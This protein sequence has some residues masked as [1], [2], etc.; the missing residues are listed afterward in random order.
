M[1]EG[2]VRDRQAPGGVLIERIRH[3]RLKQRRNRRFKWPPF[4]LN[5]PPP[6]GAT[7][8]RESHLRCGLESRDTR[9]MRLIY[10]PKPSDCWRHS[11][12]TLPHS[13]RWPLKSASWNIPNLLECLEPSENGLELASCGCARH[14]FSFST[15]ERELP[16]AAQGPVS[17]AEAQQRLYHRELSRL[18]ELLHVPLKSFKQQRFYH[19]LQMIR[20]SL[21]K[22]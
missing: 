10:L 15:K 2:I 16:G 4:I 1:E 18:L 5:A 11:R 6:A 20:T 14:F 7:Q 9:D 8:H 21:F 19:A 17:P 12:Y 13:S 22:A 3:L